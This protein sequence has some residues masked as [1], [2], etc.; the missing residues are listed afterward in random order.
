MK[1][2]KI[3]KKQG[4]SE[5]QVKSV[6]QRLQALACANKEHVTMFISQLV[7][8]VLANDRDQIEQVLPI[9]SHRTPPLLSEKLTELI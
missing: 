7:S 3:S 5:F 2:Y 9:N 4:L 6:E 1:P 8:S